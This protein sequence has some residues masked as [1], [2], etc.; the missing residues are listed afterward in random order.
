M[1]PTELEKPQTSNEP[2]KPS[3]AS[4]DPPTGESALEKTGFKWGPEAPS[5]L[6]GKTPQQTLD[7]YQQLASAVRQYV[8]QNQT[9]QAHAAA[10]QQQAQRA[11]QM[12]TNSKEISDTWFNDP[13]K[14]Q[15][16]L[17]AQI[18]Q[19]IGNQ[20]GGALAPLFAGQ[21]ATARDAASRGKEGL[22]QKYGREI[23]AIVANVP[24]AAKANPEL[25]RQAARLVEA[26]HLDEIVHERATS[27]AAAAGGMVETGST[28]GSPAT[29]KSASPVIEKMKESAYGQSLIAKHGE[30]GMMQKLRDLERADGTSPMKFAEMVA[31]TNVQR[32]DT[33]PG[34][35]K[36]TWKPNREVAR[37]VKTNG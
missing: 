31:R 8:T 20:V 37:D 24:L 5:E 1:P 6:Q 25:W 11:V 13:E 12:A 14:A 30:A 35:W 15:Q 36:T 19:N 7:Y 17:S 16:M 32:D 22:W 33:A 26:N 21:A 4:S 29:G 23:D 10:A 3:E 28:S 9:Q 18:Q 27:I 2:P 34:A